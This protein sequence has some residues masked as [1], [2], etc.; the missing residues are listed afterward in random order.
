MQNSSD[1]DVNNIAEALR[2]YLNE[3]PDAAA[4]IEE[5]SS[6]WLSR[7]KASSEQVQAALDLL[8]NTHDLVKVQLVDGKVIYRRSKRIYWDTHIYQYPEISNNTIKTIT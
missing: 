3:N 4:T 5:V 8:V 6:Y 7:Y 1:T 2:R